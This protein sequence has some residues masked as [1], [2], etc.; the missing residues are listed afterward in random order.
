MV[1]AMDLQGK[2]PGGWELQELLQQNPVEKHRVS[3]AH[4]TEELQKSIFLREIFMGKNLL[5][6]KI[7]L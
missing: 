4:I 6:N 3:I 2:E 1:V 7:E 5:L